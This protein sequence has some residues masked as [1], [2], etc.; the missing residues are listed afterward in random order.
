MFIFIRIIRIDCGTAIIL[1]D[2]CVRVIVV[3]GFLQDAC[4]FHQSLESLK[5]QFVPVKVQDKD[6]LCLYNAKDD[7]ANAEPPHK[8]VSKHSHGKCSVCQD[9]EHDEPEH[10][11]C[12]EEGQ[13]I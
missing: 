3:I 11:E 5:N 6:A 4:I 13:L 2:V 7:A 1:V 10:C 9:W 8:L 12:N